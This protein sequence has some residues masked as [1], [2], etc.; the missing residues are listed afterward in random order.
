MR[1]GWAV[2]GGPGGPA[3]WTLLVPSGRGIWCL[4]ARLPVCRGRQ[5]VMGMCHCQHI[6]MACSPTVR[7]K[8][9]ISDEGDC[10]KPDASTEMLD[11]IVEPEKSEQDVK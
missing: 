6:H 3:K 10:S 5:A 4:A 2:G 1:L 9:E 8:R 7:S 11:P